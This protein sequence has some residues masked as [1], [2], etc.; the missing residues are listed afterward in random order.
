MRQVV[1][2]KTANLVELLLV[3]NLV[4][5]NESGLVPGA[6]KFTLEN[7]GLALFQWAHPESRP[8]S[9]Y[10]QSDGA[11]S[12]MGQMRNEKFPQLCQI[13]SCVDEHCYLCKAVYQATPGFGLCIMNQLTTGLSPFV[14]S[15]DLA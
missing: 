10:Q 5:N 11:T 3:S 13:G 2:S 12:N 14:A 7:H 9:V 6:M 1:A 15:T 4:A 8:E